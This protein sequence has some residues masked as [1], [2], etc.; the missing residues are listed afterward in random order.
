MLLFPAAARATCTFT[1]S[2]NQVGGVVVWTPTPTS[3]PANL[4][5]C[6]PN[7]NGVFSNA[8]LRN[9]PIATSQGGTLTPTD[10]ASQDQFAY[11]PKVG[12]YGTDSATFYAWNGS[13][14]GPYTVTIT[15]SPVIPTLSSV[16]PSSSSASGG[17]S[18]TLSGAA[19]TGAT[20]VQFGSVNAPAFTVNSDSSITATAPAGTANTT[21]DITVTTPG[22]TSA[23]GASDKFTYNAPPTVTAVSPSGGSA[24]GGTSVTLS[25][26]NFTGV[27][28]VK[29][30]GGNAASFTVNSATS[31]TATAPAG[32]G[33]VDVTVTTSGGGT[34]ATS[35]ADQFTYV[36][37]PAVS[38]VSPSS[39]PVAGGTS[40]TISGTNFTGAT[41]VKF[42][43]TNASSFTVNSA[44][45]ITAT[46]PAGSGAVDVTVT[47]PGGTSATSG[48]DQFTYVPAPAVS[49]VSP[50]SGP[51]AGGTSVTIGGTNFTGATAVKFGGTNASSFTVNSATSITAT[52]PAG[53]GTVDVTVTTSNGTSVTSGAD[54]FTYVQPPVAGAA[55]VTVAHGSTNDAVTLNLSGGAATSVAVATAAAHG[56]ATASG[57]GM[58]YTPN[59]SYSGVDSFTYTATNSAGTSSPA[60]VT[61]TVSS[62]TL[63]YAPAAPSPGAVGV[64][65]S[66]SVASASGGTGPYTYAL[67]TGSLPPGV[68][69]SSNGTLSGT[70]IAAGTFTFTVAATDSSTGTGPFSAISGSLNLTISAPTIALSPGTL[71]SPTVGMTSSQS[72]S[73][74][75]GTA[76]YTY[77]ITAGTLPAGMSLSSGGVLS[78]TPTAGGNF[79]FTV[80]ATDSSTGTGPFTG[81]R[82]YTLT[83]NAP[84]LSITPAAGSLSATTSVAYSQSFAA[85]NGRAPYTY[86]L[87][88]NSGTLPTG[89]SF[90]AATGVLSGTPTTAGTVNFTVSGTDSSTGTGPYT[91]SATYTLA[92][93]APTITVSPATLPSASTGMAY[94]Q[95]VTASGGSAPYTYAVS[96]GA[97]PTGLSLNASTGALGGTPT[98]AGTFG[99]TV[100]GTDANGYSGTRNYSLTVAAPTIVLSPATLSSATVG[101]AYSQTVTSSGGI[102]PYTYAVTSGALPAGMSLASNGVLSGTPTAGGSFNVTISA[103]DSTAG[104]GPFTG[105]QAYTLTVNSPTLTIAPTST[106]GLTAT[107]GSSYSQSFTASGGSSPYNYAMTIN[108]GTMPAGLSF[109]MATRTLSGTPTAAGTVSF[110]LTVTDSSSGS[111]PYVASG[112]YTLTVHAPTLSVA[113]STLPN[114]V[115]GAA[116]SQTL[117]AGNGT[118][119]YTFAITGGALPAGLSLSSTGVL[120][121][122]P[123]AGGNFSFT[124]TTTDANSFTA[125]R[126]YSVT[127]GAAAVALTP[128]TV[129][130]ATLSTA[131]S[132]TLTASG[133]IG[134]YTYAVTSGALP[135]GMNLNSTTGVLSGTPTATGSSTFTIRATDSSTGTG[136]PYSG[137][138]SYTLAVGQTIGVASPMSATTTSVAPVTLHA[139]ANAIGGP[140]TAV[141]IVTQPASGTAVVNGMDIVYTPAPTTSGN[142]PFTFALVNTAGTSAPIQATVTVNAVPIAASQKTASTAAGQL[143]N[144]SLTDGAS[145]GPFTG[146]TI[147]SVTPA[148]AGTA[149]IVQQSAQGTGVA[150]AMMVAGPDYLLSF[151]PA[152]TFSGTATIT[153]TLSNAVATSAAAAIQ[154]SVMPRKDPS[155]DPDVTGLI[156]AQIQAAQRFATAQ[157]GNYNQRL[158]A[159]HGTGRAPSGNG[160]T[161][162][163]PNSRGEAQV[164][165]QDVF[166]VTARDACL[167]GDSTAGKPALARGTR[168]ADNADSKGAA[169]AGLDRPGADAAGANQSDVAFWSAGTLDF[170]FA[171]TGTQRAGFRFTTG[172]ITAGAD[173]RVSDQFSIG[174]GFGY[175]HD[176]TDIGSAGTKS[177]GDSYSVALYGSYRPMPTLFV[178]GV[179]GFGTLSFDSRRWVSDANDFATG[180]RNG[181]Q[182]FA[183]LSAGYE[184]R[185]STWL[186]SPYGRLS[187]SESTLDQFSETGAGLN[188]LTYFA[189]TVTTVS[190][191]LGLRS[192]LEQKTRWGTFLPYARV[193][194]QH[195]FNGQSNAGLAYADLAS[196]GPAYT[197]SGSPYGRDSMQIGVGTKFRTGV[198]TFGLDYS[199]MFGMGGLQQGV[200]LTFGGPF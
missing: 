115:I 140:F 20:A 192:E 22:G 86:V 114:P 34:S 64:A 87:S 119:P 161:V 35:G 159:L 164:R 142:V 153:Y 134:P 118:A 40:V 122:T 83:V 99:F 6:D 126:A 63:S 173:Y 166:D 65:Y 8:A 186:I 154:V 137:T 51:A 88:V 146:A 196:F 109:N 18:V 41:A 70:P 136:A 101:T 93:S 169:G 132:Q 12:F 150:K 170:G 104:A 185:D 43:S 123:T 55:S 197:V 111:G 117:T 106:S 171:N 48:A 79:N 68:T 110:T 133:G 24:A 125:S 39:G 30:G 36:P 188:A 7:G 103:T 97:L 82:N 199:V 95:S 120:S 69:L 29:F 195:D 151:T 21:V 189:Q 193:E 67:A 26:A 54:Q 59:A 139:T 112:T 49:S 116:Y 152:A 198:F 180:N 130:G 62:A 75:G 174:A 4:V 96:S 73:A 102:A 46:A 89:L 85:A 181:R 3:A 149:T 9:D 78:G 194:Y 58:T 11:T 2:E 147:V 92:T 5:G 176:S 191:T 33:T 177:M 27:T 77:A 127:I 47:T 84:T 1:A 23:V 100:R 165:C 190:G 187:V 175:G 148:N 10:P 160:I 172:G 158:E 74:S 66:Q 144:V 76:P 108:S 129:P 124:V 60:T 52:A 131:Y 71:T 157:I 56:T 183:S 44:T 16:S 107:A 32:S 19:L 17:I 45:S 98:A 53:S 179:A 105:S 162:A 42:G 38:S 138:H 145:G 90:N 81:S 91:V 57:T 141:T 80:T 121:G 113:P 61:V 28:A 156:N 155:T 135:A 15:V 13:N 167:R 72:V 31:I 128:A 163:M 168:N 37:A 25:G 182:V 178:D 143:V 184:R 14:Y 200:R 50:S 94:S